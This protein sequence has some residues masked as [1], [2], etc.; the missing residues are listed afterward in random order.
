[1]PRHL[2]KIAVVV[3]L[4]GPGAALARHDMPAGQTHEQHLAELKK[5]A[6]QKSRGREAMGFDQERT[7]HHFILQPD[8]GIISVEANDPADALSRDAIR[9]H[10]RR[11]A[12][13]FAA[14]RFN[15]P[16]ATHGEEPPGAGVMRALSTSIRYTV[17]ITPRGARVRIASENDAAVAAVHDFLRYQ[18]REHK[19]GDSV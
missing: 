2:L 17:E 3:A 5:D 7:T 8:G 14:G 12:A 6:D 15:A 10:M 4:G 9:T 18:I 16:L 1:M 11:I 13:D 19:T